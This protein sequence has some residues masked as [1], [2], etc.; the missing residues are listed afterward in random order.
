MLGSYPGALCL[1]KLLLPWSFFPTWNVEQ[2]CSFR[3]CAPVLGRL[4]QVPRYF[5]PLFL[6]LM[7]IGKLM[8]TIC[9]IFLR[10]CFSQYS[11]IWRKPNLSKHPGLLR[12]QGGVT[13]ESLEVSLLSYS[14]ASKWQLF[15]AGQNAFYAKRISTL[16]ASCSMFVC[17]AGRVWGLAT[18]PL[19]WFLRI[20]FCSSSEMFSF[21]L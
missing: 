19:D 14:R 2:R 6:L 8:A 21:S 12:C 16:S 10:G 5:I 3:N 17:V 11:L 1:N 18:R 20:F 13:T 15:R 7:D 4:L 9:S